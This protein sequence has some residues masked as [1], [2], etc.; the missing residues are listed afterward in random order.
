MLVPGSPRTNLQLTWGTFVQT[1]N[2]SLTGVCGVLTVGRYVIRRYSLGRWDWDDLAH[3]FAFL[4]LVVHGAMTQ[5]KDDAK[6]K[7]ALVLSGRIKASPA[8][9]IDKY[10]HLSH[11][12]TV[13]NCCLYLDFWLVKL[14]LLLFYRFLFKSSARFNK[15]WWLVLAFVLL[16]FWVPIA[17]VLATCS[18]A[19]TLSDYSRN[20]LLVMREVVTHAH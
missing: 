11:L 14:S 6:A 12:N 3:L 16:S 20:S 1:V 13:K 18:G 10:R 5:V 15:I 7:L 4:V 17:G 8:Q 2:W 19:R 9:Q